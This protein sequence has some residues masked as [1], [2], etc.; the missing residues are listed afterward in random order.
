MERAS[1]KREDGVYWCDVLFPDAGVRLA[2]NKIAL[3]APRTVSGTA[4]GERVAVVALD[5]QSL[6]GSAGGRSQPGSVNR[7]GRSPKNSDLEVSD[8][9][10]DSGVFRSQVGQETEIQRFAGPAAP[11][12]ARSNPHFLQL[13]EQ[14]PEFQSIL[15]SQQSSSLKSAGG[16]AKLKGKEKR[17]YKKRLQ[18]LHE[19]HE[20]ES[21]S[22]GV[23]RGGTVSQLPAQMASID[24]QP[25]FSS[26]RKVQSQIQPLEPRADSLSRASVTDQINGYRKQQK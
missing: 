6:A 1:L 5:S 22:P 18:E 11:A 4:P 21:Q 15:Q 24:S 9:G 8:L 20:A 2:T 26:L 16:I 25:A 23:S 17:E 19:Q 12:P 14:S 3:G 13:Q 7:R 10:Y